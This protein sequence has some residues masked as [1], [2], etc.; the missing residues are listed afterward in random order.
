MTTDVPGPFAVFLMGVYTV[1]IDRKTLIITVSAIK[2]IMQNKQLS[3]TDIF[4][5]DA[6][7]ARDRIA[8]WVKIKD[9]V[10]DKVHGTY[11]GCY[12][13]EGNPGFSDQL[14][15]ILT[16]SDGV[17]RG[18]SLS[19]TSYMTEIE[20]IWKVGDRVG[21]KYEGDKDTGKPQPAKIIK[22]Y[23]P[24]LEARKR[25]GSQPSPTVTAA[26]APEPAGNDELDF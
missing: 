9:N 2:K 11:E 8:D 15:V 13:K 22:K 14:V 5:A 24:D 3:E 23:N 21:F 25:D 6:L 18:L 19:A 1:Y 4:N 17:T 10:G 16:M 26:P 12:R 7:P 20:Q